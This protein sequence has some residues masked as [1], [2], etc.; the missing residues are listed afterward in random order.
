MLE[1][2]NKILINKENIEP[3]KIDDNEIN[4]KDNRK[5]TTNNKKP[6]SKYLK[7]KKDK[8][9]YFTNNTNKEWKFLEIRGYNQT[10]YFKCRDM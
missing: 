7:D 9:Y 6:L 2:S 10:Y 8:H 4:I 5:I 3:Q 1:E